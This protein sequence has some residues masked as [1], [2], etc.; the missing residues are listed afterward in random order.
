MMNL[1]RALEDDLIQEM[2]H[3]LAMNFNKIAS[4]G[5]EDTAK[6]LTQD[7]FVVRWK[8]ISLRK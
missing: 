5:M 1:R 4:F 3:E 6:E 2:T 7:T 8:M